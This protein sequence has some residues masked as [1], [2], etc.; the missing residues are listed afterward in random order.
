MAKTEDARADLAEAADFPHSG[1]PSKT[2]PR[3]GS[4]PDSTVNLNSKK[5]G[6]AHCTCLAGQCR[7]CR[8]LPGKQRKP[9]FTG[10]R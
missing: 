8:R 9:K 2:L 7:R 6:A 4:A 10:P 3:R 1:A 5:P